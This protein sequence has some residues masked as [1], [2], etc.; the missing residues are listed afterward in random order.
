MLFLQY[1]N[2]DRRYTMNRHF[3]ALTALLLAAV[4][5]F[6]LC[7]CR[8]GEEDPAETTAA[9]REEK[10]EE[11]TQNPIDQPQ[12]I[13]DFTSLYS[14][15]NIASDYPD[16]PYVLTVGGQPVTFDEYRYAL[17][18]VRELLSEGDASYFTA[19]PKMESFAEETA[20]SSIKESHALFSEAKRVGKGLSPSEKAD[21]DAQVEAEISDMGGE[22][23][24]RESFA[25]YDGTLW[26]YYYL[27][28]TE[29]LTGVLQKYYTEN[30]PVDME[31][32]DAMHEFL[33]GEHCAYFHRI[34][35]G[36]DPGDDISANAALAEKTKQRL[37]GGEDFMTVMHE[38]SED[39]RDVQDAGFCDYLGALDESISSA[40]K[41]T[42]IGKHS[43]VIA[44]YYG[45]LILLREPVTDEIAEDNMAVVRE[46]LGEALLSGPITE[47]AAGME[48]VP[49]ENYDT[50]YE[51][52]IAD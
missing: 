40:L 34:F 16:I 24:M 3:Q 23:V 7:A 13:S 42:P 4:L 15:A 43:E 51:R 33:L 18:Y 29:Y 5:L 31:N 8:T 10:T 50:Y 12:I 6:S 36:N 20:I 48:V 11:V 26:L 39:D 22:D 19:F 46:S 37:D 9:D 1:C 35:I 2:H 41:A 44:T 14:F 27:N 52:A 32:D 30:A 25:Q 47:A 38:V 21:L 17:R 49:S 45:Y 28:A